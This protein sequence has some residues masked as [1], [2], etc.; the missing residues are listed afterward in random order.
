MRNYRIT[1]SAAMAVAFAGLGTAQTNLPIEVDA[2]KT[3]SVK[4]G[5]NFLLVHGRLLTVTHG[6]LE[7]ADILVT[8]GKIAKIGRGLV[9]PTNYTVFDATGK[10]VT[11]GLVDAHSHRGE[12]TTNEWTDSIVAE[13]QIRDVLDSMQKGL[14]DDVANGI[15]SGLTLHGSSD[16]IGGQS[17]VIKH[18]WRRAP[19]DL[20]FPG[21]PRMI[22][23]AL[24]ENVTQKNGGDGARFPTSRMGVEATIRKGFDD[25][26]A[27]MKLW[28]DYEKSGGLLPQPRKDLRLEALADIL[29][30]KIWV[31]CHSYRQSEMLMLV[32]L[33]QE[34]GFKIGSMQHALES[35]KIATELAA[36]KVPVSMFSSGWGYKLEVF[37]AIPMGSALCIQAGVLTSINTDTFQGMPPLTQDAAK[38]MRYG[39]SEEDALKTITLNPAKQLGVDKFVGS[40]DEGKDADISVWDGHPLSI[41]SKC[42]MTFVDGEL[43]FKRRDAFGVDKYSTLKFQTRPNALK[44]DLAQPL[45]WSRVYALKGGMVHTVSGGDIAEGVVVIRDGKIEEVGGPTTK[46]PSEAVVVNTS[47]QHVYPGF[48]DGGSNLGLNEMGLVQQSTDDGENGQYHPELSSLIA[49]NPDS[50]KI[51]ISRSSG[52]LTS[53][54]RHGGPVVAGQGSIVNLAGYNR[55]QMAVSKLAALDVYF[56]D[57]PSALM[58]KSMK[59]EAAEKAGDNVE[60]RR[61]ELKEQFEEAQRYVKLREAGEIAVDTKLESYMPYVKGQR[62][63]MFHVDSEDGIR[64]AL[65]F[66]KALKLKAIIVGGAE[67]WKVTK[68]LVADKV[69]VIY[70]APVITN[71]SGTVD[72]YSDMDPYDSPLVAPYLLNKAGVLFCIEG[73]NASD[74][75]ELSFRAGWL[76]AYGLTREAAVRSITLD[77]AKILGIDSM[78]GSLDKGKIAN[79]IV[80]DGDPLE[81]TTHV[82]RAFVGG[83]PVGMA[84]HFTELYRKFQKRLSR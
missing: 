28:E 68:E 40:L 65:K 21:A 54:V 57:G 38:L 79:V 39:I 56:P 22:K 2:D 44:A 30:G 67:S 25:A 37:E 76:C 70:Q 55:E 19:S 51:P 58:K 9:A 59:P 47:G 66:A 32:R 84:N 4:T 73:G 36:A 61:A 15:T 35:Y 23:F 14:W 74:L 17:I 43:E 1:L 75:H 53:Y 5:G 81:I 18:K 29:K 49:M 69:P 8:N 10:I 48:I 62:P 50:V 20:V 63:V 60:A 16:S 3:P 45:K 71:P 11:P 27:Y 12:A 52:V 13:T 77:A 24:G 7:D 80:T 83:K 78:L 46:I 33:S 82:Q 26:K 41:Y 64:E 31:Q 34:Y 6:V 72:P 42:A